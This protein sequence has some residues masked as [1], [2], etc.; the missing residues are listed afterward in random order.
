M[1]IIAKNARLEEKEPEIKIK[2]GK[3]GKKVLIEKVDLSRL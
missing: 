3:K 2:N 1:N